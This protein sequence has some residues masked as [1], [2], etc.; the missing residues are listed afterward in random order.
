MN[1]QIEDAI[2]KIRQQQL[3]VWICPNLYKTTTHKSMWFGLIDQGIEIV[4]LAHE[5]LFGSQW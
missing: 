2:Q 4:I 3:Q 5:A 1:E